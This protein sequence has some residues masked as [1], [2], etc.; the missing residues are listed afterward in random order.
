MRL[1]AAA[2]LVCIAVPLAAQE[3]KKQPGKARVVL[4]REQLAQQFDTVDVVKNIVK[5]NPLLFFR[6]EM[7]IHFERA[8]TPRLSLDVGMGVTLRNYLA[9]SFAGDH[10]DADDFGAGTEIIPNLS[11]HLGARFYLQDDLEPQGLYLAPVWSHLVYT[12]DIRELQADGSFTDKRYRDE[13]T[14]NDLR[15][16]LGYQSLGYS[17]NWLLDFYGGIGFRNRNMVIVNERL[18]LTTSPGQYTYEVE[19]ITDNVPAI[20]L[21]IRFGVGF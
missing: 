9:L 17:S 10:P 8:L 20:F 7:P 5:I 18:D 4:Y 19:E 6:G 15:L 1:I 3:R 12:K 21:G 11:F 14:F 13:R 2:L 16:L